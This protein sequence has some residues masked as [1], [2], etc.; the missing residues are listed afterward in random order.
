M[1]IL[2]VFMLSWTII[3]NIISQNTLRDGLVAHYRFNRHTLKDSTK[4]IDETTFNNGKI[5]GKVFY[6]NDRY[7]NPCAALFFDGSTHVNVPNSKSLQKPSKEITIAV[8]FKIHK[9]A[10]FFNQWITICC[11]SNI[12]EENESSPQYRMQATAQ[13]ISLNSSFTKNV[14]PQLSYDK[15][16]FYAYTYDGK[17]VKGYLDG[18][19]FFEESYSGSLKVNDM[20]LEIGRDTPGKM[21]KFYG[22]MDDLRIYDRALSKAELFELF[23][24]QEDAIANDFCQKSI[25]STNS[26]LNTG[27]DSLNTLLKQIDTTPID[28][29]KTIEVMNSDIVIYP[30]DNNIDD[31]DIISINVNGKWVKE[32]YMIKAKLDTPPNEDLIQVKVIKGYSNFIVSK[33]IHEGKIPLNTLTFMIDDGI[34]KQNIKLNSRIGLSGAIRIVY[35]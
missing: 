18:K 11:K 35:K 14:I 33:A 23:T 16:Y 32:N 26:S 15:W 13:T 9:G 3:S 10:D 20:P 6:E 21:E 29:Q 27:I 5:I 31:G 34:T 1:K 17:N 2:L 4:V 19:Y 7:N 8:W 30:Y 22:S 25:Q 12:F 28:F 24:N